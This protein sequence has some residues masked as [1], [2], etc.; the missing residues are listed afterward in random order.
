MIIRDRVEK[1]E[2]GKVSARNICSATPLLSQEARADL[3]AGQI[4]TCLR[5]IQGPNLLVSH[6]N[7]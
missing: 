5:P 6:L 1:K 3:L 4:T 7:K 2:A